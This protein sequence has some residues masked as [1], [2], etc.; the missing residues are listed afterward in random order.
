MQK[1]HNKKLEGY[2]TLCILLTEL[3]VLRRMQVADCSST[4]G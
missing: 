2:P 1:K 4:E 3:S